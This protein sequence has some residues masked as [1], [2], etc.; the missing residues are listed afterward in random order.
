MKIYSMTATFGKLSHQTLTLKPGLNIIEAPNEW[1]KSTWCAFLVAMLYGIDT[2]SRT[3]KDF[4]ADKERYQPWSGEPMS[5]RMDI[6]WNGRDITIERKT[7]GRSIF[8]QFAAYETA[9]GIPVTELTADNCGQTLLG[10]EQSVFTR[11]GF[12]RLKD[13]PVQQDETLRRRLNALVTTGD[14]SD[15]ADKLAQKL[16]DIK[17]RCRFNRTGLL[18]QAEA[19]QREL[20]EKL[21]RID[22]L[23]QQQESIRLRRESLTEKKELLENH[24]QHL[25]Y[26]AG[27]EYAKKLESALYQRDLARETAQKARLACENLP[28]E[29]VLQQKLRQMQ[30]L[31]EQKE[32]LQMELQMQPGAPAVPEAL[33]QFRG[34]DPQ[35]VVEETRGDAKAYEALLRSVKK[36]SPVLAFVGVGVMALG[37]VLAFFLSLIPGIAVAAAGL[38]LLFVGLALSSGQNR[39]N[40]DAKAKAEKIA[41]RYYPLEVR[42]WVSEAESYAQTQVFYKTALERFQAGISGLEERLRSLKNQQ[43]ELTKGLSLG[44]FEEMLHRSIRSHGE[45]ADALREQSRLEEMVSTLAGAGRQVQK[46]EKPDTLTLSQQETERQLSDVLLALRDEEGRLARNRGFMESLGSREVL[47][48]QLEQ[49]AQRI[50]QLEQTYSA[51]ELAMATLQEAKL[52]LQRRFAPRIAK[53]AQELFSRLTGGRYERLSLQEDLSVLAAA[54]GEDTLHSVLWRSEGTADQLYLALRLAVAEE[55]TPDAPLVLDDA[56]VRFDDQR[57]KTA[58]QIL[59]E[60]AENKQVLLFTCQ[61]REEKLR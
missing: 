35:S 31:K 34:K 32:A 9:T 50:A 6:C 19:T 43:E 39:K 16:K 23:E 7:K 29:G 51:A 59:T 49:T 40:T 1:G 33:P 60:T 44:E 47:R 26:E 55:L 18:P 41:G 13:L 42:H 37:A 38:V 8:G 48:K 28:E 53:R 17:N 4:L 20:Q 3:K 61:G 12:L 54:E 2:S 56:L 27:R 11:A 36:P 14:E 22:A 25:Q 52:E 21:D 58:L 46:P 30:R 15:S 45:L 24:R 10:V 57:L 5:G